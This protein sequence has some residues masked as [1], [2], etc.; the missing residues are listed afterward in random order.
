MIF[1]TLSRAAVSVLGFVFVTAIFIGFSGSAVMAEDGGW[2]LC[3]NNDEF[4]T[5]FRLE[6]CRFLTK[7]ENPFFILKPGYQ[8]VLESEE[9]KSVETVLD[10]TKLID[11]DGRMIKTR[12]LEERAY[13]FDVDEDTGEVEEKLIEISLNWFA[14]CEKTNSVFY[15]GEWSRDCPGGFDENDGCEGESNAGSWEAGKP[16]MD[17]PDGEIAMPGIMMPGTPLLG[18]KYFQ[19][20]APPVALDRGQI[21]EMGLAWPEPEDDLAQDEEPDFT[22]CI[23]IIDTN[24]VAGECEEEGEDADAKIYC[25]GIGLVQDQDLELISYGFVNDDGDHYHHRRWWGYKKHRRWH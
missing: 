3:G 11:L 5:E 14:I 9:E 12:V 17:D 1:K 19:E 7:G 18:A 20:I 8:V 6:D 15:F 25:P 21:E 2:D 16:P 23:K 24:P 22:G 13:E 10:D 4:T